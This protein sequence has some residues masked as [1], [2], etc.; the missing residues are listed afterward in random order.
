MRH[1]RPVCVAVLLGILSVWLIHYGWQSR[2]VYYHTYTEE[3]QASLR[4][5][6][7]AMYRLG[8]RAWY[9]L[10]PESA[11]EYFEKA[12]AGDPLMVNGWLRLAET[13]QA[14]GQGDEA[15][16]ILGFAHGL[17]GRVLRWTWQEVLLAEELGEDGIFWEGINRLVEAGRSVQDAFQ[18]V[19]SKVEG[20]VSSA[21]E[22]L[23]PENLPAYLRWLMGWG[24]IEDCLL[25]RDHLRPE[26]REDPLLT[27]QVVH[28]L[29]EKKRL[30]DA[31]GITGTGGALTNPGFEEEPSRKGFDWRYPG[32]SKLPFVVRRVK[33]PRFEGVSALEI[34]FFGEQNLVFGHVT[35]IVPV[36]PSASYALS[37]AWKTQGITT[38]QGPFVEVV[39]YDAKGLHCKGPMMLGTVDWTQEALVFVTPPDCHGV[40]VR[41]A[42]NRSKKIDSKITGRL[43]LD[44][45]HLEKTFGQ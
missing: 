1:A 45:F 42:R 27:S 43:W 2:R 13:K 29:V 3:D 21:L 22:H 6:P 12:V 11:A 9:D 38:D 4:R 5:Y 31:E 25:V 30:E 37:Y 14:M 19:D 15:R 32:P 28:F 10:R 44:G 17:T 8:M 24:R 40:V 33:D 36:E 41:V 39:G 7:E 34:A 35:Q 26:D 16:R 20:D 23:R 18:L